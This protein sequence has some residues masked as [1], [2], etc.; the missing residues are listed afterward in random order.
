MLGSFLAVITDL[1]AEIWSGGRFKSTPHRVKNVTTI[2]RLSAPFFFD[3]AFD[4][5]ITPLGGSDKAVGPWS[6]PFKYGIIF[7]DVRNNFAGDY[8]HNKV[9]CNFP[10]LAGLGK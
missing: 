7:S 4:S 8:I 6:K 5:V 10:D 1:Y 3:P 9:V 2:N